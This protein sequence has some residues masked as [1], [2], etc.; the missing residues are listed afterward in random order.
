[1]HWGWA[2]GYR[3][4]AFEVYSGDSESSL[5]DNFQIHTVADA[6]YQ[7]LITLPL[8][9]EAVG[10]NPVPDHTLVTYQFSNLKKLTLTITNMNGRVFHTA[11]LPDE[12]GSSKVP[13]HLPFGL[14]LGQSG[15][16]HPQV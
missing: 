14:Y 6:N 8:N 9:A 3:F 10:D 12:T 1:M 4:I 16:E 7:T 13:A 2:S 5:P 15:S 11:A